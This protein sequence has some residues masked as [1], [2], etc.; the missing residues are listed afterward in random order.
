MR[1]IWRAEMRKRLFGHSLCY[2][3]TMKLCSACLLGINCTWSNGNKLN[4]KVIELSK[5]EVLIPV[6]PEQLG[7]LTTPRT[8]QEILNGSGQDVISGKGKVL[9]KDN[10]DVT[11]YFL[12]GAEETLQIAKMLGV[13]EF[14]GKQKSP[15]CGCGLT[16]DGTFSGTLIKADGVTTAYLKINGLKVIP[17]EKI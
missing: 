12:K 11:Q 6:C 8:P 10:K 16:Y 4:P 5:T 7:G 1:S 17:E 15:S 13:K 2:N 3:G 9:N 14:I